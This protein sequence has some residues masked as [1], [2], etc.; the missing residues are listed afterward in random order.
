VMGHLDDL[1]GALKRRDHNRALGALLRL[2]SSES[3]MLPSLLASRDSKGRSVMTLAVEKDAFE[4]VQ[5]VSRR[6]LHE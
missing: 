1:V 5:L 4:V 2:K 6:L 3:W